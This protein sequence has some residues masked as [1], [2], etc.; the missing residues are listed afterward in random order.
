M[1]DYEKIFRITI[2]AWIFVSVVVLLRLVVMEAKPVKKTPN[3][4]WNKV[5]KIEF[6]S[7][8]QN[9]TMQVELSKKYGLI[10]KNI[11]ECP[12]NT[13]ISKT[14]PTG[15][16]TSRICSKGMCKLVISF[17]DIVPKEIQVNVNNAQTGQCM[18]K[19]Y[20]VSN[21]MSVIGYE[22]KLPIS[23]A[24]KEKLDFKDKK[25]EINFR[26]ANGFTRSQVQ[27]REEM[28]FSFTKLY[29][30]DMLMLDGKDK[31]KFTFDLK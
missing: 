10:I 17:N 19:T 21:K 25:Q 6:S 30:E 15:Y 23:R 4:F 13:M 24:L 28:L 20:Q 11:S 26:H 27:G 14:R 18:L 2:Y 22:V 9:N 3:A 12:Y 7:P 1:N 29:K 8:K 31:I 16:T 5:S